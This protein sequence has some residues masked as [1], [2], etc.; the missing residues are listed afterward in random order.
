VGRAS[1]AAGIPFGNG[2]GVH[3]RPMPMDGSSA[4]AATIS[5]CKS[6]MQ[7]GTPGRR[8]GGG[9]A[10][11]WHRALGAAQRGGGLLRMRVPA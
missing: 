4:K 7:F 9:S 2:G 5:R 3:D 10:R 6:L 1:R 11:G 8:S